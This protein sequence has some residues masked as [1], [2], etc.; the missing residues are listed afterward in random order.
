MFL[1][2]ADTSVSQSK[3]ESTS[4]EKESAMMV[5]MLLDD[6]DDDDDELPEKLH[7]YVTGEN[8]QPPTSTVSNAV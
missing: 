7:A 4:F 2:N 5:D 3:D 6:G 8:I 1:L